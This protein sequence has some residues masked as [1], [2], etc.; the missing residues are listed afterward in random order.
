MERALTSVMT[1]DLP[2][3]A[4]FWSGKATADQMELEALLRDE[5][6]IDGAPSVA[7]LV[8]ALQEF[9]ARTPSRLVGIALA[10]AIADP[11]QPNM[12]GT[13]DEYPNWRLPLYDL[14]TGMPMLLDRM[15]DDARVQRLILAL[16]RARGEKPVFSQT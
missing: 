3:A 9:V 8:L 13:I 4:G 10:D 7:E 15:L 16:R 5:D 6:L 2:T 12:P 14:V 1:H 11:R